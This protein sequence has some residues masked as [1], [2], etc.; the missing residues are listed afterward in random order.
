M[1]RELSR[2]IAYAQIDTRSDPR[3]KERPSSSGQKVLANSVYQELSEAGLRGDEIIFLEDGS[4]FVKLD[5]C[6]GLEGTTAVAFSAHF[7]TY[8]ECPGNA[9]PLIH[10]YAGGDLF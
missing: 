9:K 4:L 2:F 8:F 3:I 7:D 1:E 6:C 10:D 5:P